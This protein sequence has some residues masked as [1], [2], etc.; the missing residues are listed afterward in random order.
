[1]TAVRIVPLPLAGRPV[2]GQCH[3]VRPGRP[4]LVWET[5]GIT[6][7][8]EP[9]LEPRCCARA[10]ACSASPRH[11]RSAPSGHAHRMR[12]VRC[13]LYGEPRRPLTEAPCGAPKPARAAL[14][15]G[16]ACVLQR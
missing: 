3:G 13:A 6:P 14:T 16:R 7:D 12:A 5:L 15:R 4:R 1:M 11:T 8:S 2:H 10:T 9:G